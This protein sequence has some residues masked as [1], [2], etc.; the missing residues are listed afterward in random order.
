MKLSSF[1]FVICFG[2]TILTGCNQSESANEEPSVLPTRG[3][4]TFM[5]Y[6]EEK[7]HT[8]YR[9]LYSQVPDS[10]ITQVKTVQQLETD[11][12]SE[13]N[14]FYER[15]DDGIFGYIVLSENFP[16]NWTAKD[17]RAFPKTKIIS[18]P[19]VAGESW[20][21]TPEGLDVEITYTVRSIN[22][23]VET[24]A[25]TF[26]NTIVIDFEEKDRSGNLLRTGSSS[27]APE[28][29]WIGHESSDEFLKDVHE[30]IHIND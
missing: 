15:L 18:Y 28:Y 10:N 22:A 25:K 8:E 23:V 16:E 13:T 3:D 19:P 6:V 2:V 27:F 21:E 1:L 7:E 4:Y 26:N 29:G 20:T 14:N 30:L 5:R 17:I 9:V 12:I 24:P 11:E